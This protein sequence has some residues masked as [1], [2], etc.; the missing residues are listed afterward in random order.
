MELA[1]LLAS[2]SPLAVY[3]TKRGNVATRNMSMD[4]ARKYSDGCS[5]LGY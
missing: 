1:Q 3:S 4:D 2:K 5:S